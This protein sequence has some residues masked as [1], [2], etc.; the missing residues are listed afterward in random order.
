ME[1]PTDKAFLWPIVYRTALSLAANAVI[2]ETPYF[3]ERG[4]NAKRVEGI[5]HHV[6]EFDIFVIHADATRTASQRVRTTIIDA[7]RDGVV[8]RCRID[9][10]RVVGLVTV[11][12]MESWALA[13]EHAV[14]ESLGFVSWPDRV[15]L[16]WNPANVE[17]LANPKQT[18]RDAFSVLLGRDLDHVSLHETLEAMAS[19]ISLDKLAN[20]PSYRRF[21]DD[22]KSCLVAL[23]A[24]G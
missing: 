9:G 18:L 12:E 10:V 21:R 6:N 20:L 15:P 5:G 19:N 3:V 24:A 4:T 2:Q 7:I 11:S 8:A 17:T 22:L 16:H 14:A 1:G 13:S 23:R